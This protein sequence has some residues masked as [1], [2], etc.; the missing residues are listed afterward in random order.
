MIFFLKVHHQPVSL[1][2]MSCGVS[3]VQ[4]MCGFSPTVCMYTCSQCVF[5]CLQAMAT[6]SD[7]FCCQRLSVGIAFVIV[8]YSLLISLLED[9][10]MSDRSRTVEAGTLLRSWVTKSACWRL[11]AWCNAHFVVMCLV[12]SKQV[13]LGAVQLAGS[14]RPCNCWYTLEVQSTWC[15]AFR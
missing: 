4:C 13:D 6:F 8:V 3:D 2:Q 9:C 1:W 11:E 12:H 14:F 5:V 15:P 7:S 10:Y